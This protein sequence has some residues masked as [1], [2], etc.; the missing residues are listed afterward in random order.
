M[1]VQIPNF[2]SAEEDALEHKLRLFSEHKLR[3][4]EEAAARRIRLLSH[5][6]YLEE[7]ENRTAMAA[8]G[9]IE[10]ARQLAGDTG[11]SL[12]AALVALCTVETSKW[13]TIMQDTLR[14][15]REAKADADV[16]D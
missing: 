15:L 5:P 4:L 16:Q 9:L 13:W 12:E 7:Q 6:L 3:F 8:E 10:R 14:M 1:P 2:P 11:T